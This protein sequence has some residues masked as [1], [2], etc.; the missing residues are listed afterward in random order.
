MKRGP[1]P[2]SPELKLIRGERADRLNPEAPKADGGAPECPAHLDD[3]ARAEWARVL[4]E[5]RQLGVLS[6]T[7]RAVIALYCDYYSQ[8]VRASQWVARTG[9]TVT[10][11]KGAEK[12]NPAVTIGRAATVQMARLL[13]ELGLTPSARNRVRASGNEARKDPLDAF[14]MRRPG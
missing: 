7:D 10:T 2:A 4:D 9:L 6:S 14:L 3:E 11:D 8:W 13:S 1:K 12:T 5:L